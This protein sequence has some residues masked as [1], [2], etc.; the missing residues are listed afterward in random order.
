MCHT[1]HHDCKGKTKYQKSNMILSFY[2][3]TPV[4]LPYQNQNTKT[5]ITTKTTTTTTTKTT[6]TQGQ[7]KNPQGWRPC[8]PMETLGRILA[9]SL[10]ST[11]RSTYRAH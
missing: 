5:T 3:A 8:L 9:N 4:I 1:K 2:H 10:G 7:R 6:T 11:D